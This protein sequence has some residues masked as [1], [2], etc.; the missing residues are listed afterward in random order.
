MNKF[1]VKDLKKK[2]VSL[3]AHTLQYWF[4]S[5]ETTKSHVD[6]TLKVWG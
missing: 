2:M 1:P 4:L 5:S 3:S 6:F